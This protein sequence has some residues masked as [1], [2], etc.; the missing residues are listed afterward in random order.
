MED[1]EKTKRSEKQ[2]LNTIVGGITGSITGTVGGAIV[3]SAIIPGVGTLVGSLLGGVFSGL[4]LGAAG[5]YLGSKIPTYS[6]KKNCLLVIDLQNDFCQKGALEVEGAEDVIDKVNTIRDR[7]KFDYICLTRDAHPL[8]H[9]SFA[10]RYNKNPGEYHELEN[11]KRQRLWPNHCIVG[12]YGY[13]FHPKLTIE[14][15]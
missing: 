7:H 8:G 6:R 10:T 9:V 5:A 2:T 11:G 1:K 12:S 14:K 3:G 4:S 13:E 15:K